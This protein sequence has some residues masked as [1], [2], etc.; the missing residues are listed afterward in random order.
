MQDLQKK[1]M[2]ECTSIE[3]MNQVLV[4]EQLINIMPADLKLCI[5]ERMPKTAVEAGELADQYMQA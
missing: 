1:L 4:K 2:K 3:L 5:K